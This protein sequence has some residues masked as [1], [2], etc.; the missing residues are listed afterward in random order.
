MLCFAFLE[1]KNAGGLLIDDEAVM[2][3]QMEGLFQWERLVL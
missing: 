2:K 3:D 1:E